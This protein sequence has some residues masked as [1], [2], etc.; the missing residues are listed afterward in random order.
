MKRFNKKRLLLVTLLIFLV[1][2]TL[3]IAPSAVGKSEGTV[4][5]NFLE[6]L[7]LLNKE[8]EDSYSCKINE[9]KYEETTKTL[10]I[11]TV[12]PTGTEGLAK[13]KVVE[14]VD[15]DMLWQKDVLNTA[16]SAEFRGKIDN[17]KWKVVNDEKNLIESGTEIDVQNV[18]SDFSWSKTSSEENVMYDLIRRIAEDE[19]FIIG[20]M[21]REPI[22]NEWYNCIVTMKY[23]GPVDD[24]DFFNTA[25]HQLILKVRAQNIKEGVLPQF[26]FQ[27]E[28]EGKTSIAVW[29]DYVHG[30]YLSKQSS[31]VSGYWGHS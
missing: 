31:N 11:T 9:V 5:A 13:G 16:F 29:V 15:L 19:G 21:K 10:H 26:V 7:Q 2:T 30:Y 4:S 22:Y 1:L 28:Y 17:I 18:L 8:K 14:F 24:D 25:I 12:T 6:K 20:D 27:V 23:N 3:P